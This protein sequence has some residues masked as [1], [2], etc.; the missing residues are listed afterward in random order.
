[1]SRRQVPKGGFRR[2]I[3][4]PGSHIGQADDFTTM[5]AQSVARRSARKDRAGRPLHCHAQLKL[6]YDTEEIALAAAAA[7]QQVTG[8][9]YTAYGCRH[10]NHQ[11]LTTRFQDAE[12]VRGEA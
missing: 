11:H 9:Q 6:M 1:M 4:G 3:T 5:Q 12:V 7:L 10:G 8:L 2:S